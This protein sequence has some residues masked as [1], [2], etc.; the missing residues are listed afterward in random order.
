MAR[1]AHDT[2]EKLTRLT[3]S[4]PESWGATLDRV[5]PTS[6]GAAVRRLVAYALNNGAAQVL[7]E[8]SDVEAEALNTPS[9]TR[10]ADMT[11]SQLEA[12][13]T[14]ALATA[15]NSRE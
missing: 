1:I 6:R 3:V 14:R 10:L 12:L 11:P 4:L 9:P 13:V 5:D 15:I 2:A 8:D 7:P